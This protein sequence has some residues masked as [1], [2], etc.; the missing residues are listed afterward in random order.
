MADGGHPAALHCR[1]IDGHILAEDVVIP[2]HDF[3]GL[4]FV[5]Q[6]LRRSADRDEGMELAPFTDLSPSLHGY[7]RQQARPFAERH[8]LSHHAE[9]SDDDLVG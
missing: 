5:P 1:P 7:V 6:M 8:M 3:R 9:R 4:A 2:D